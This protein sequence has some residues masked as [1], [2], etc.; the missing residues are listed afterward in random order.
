MQSLG[1]LER[2]CIVPRTSFF[3]PLPLRLVLIEAYMH[4]VVRG[5][6]T[7]SRLGVQSLG[8]NMESPGTLVLP[9]SC[10]SYKRS[11]ASVV[12]SLGLLI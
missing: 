2:M 1:L 4:G 12:Q 5:A 3:A 7:S 8:M 10:P 11:H 6:S 9:Y